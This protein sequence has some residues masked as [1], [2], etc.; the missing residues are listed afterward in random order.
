[1]KTRGFVRAYAPILADAGIDESTW[2]EFLKGFDKSK[3]QHKYFHYVNAAVWVADKVRT[4]VEG[5]SIIARFVTMAI[6]LSVEA[7]RRAYMNKEE[8]KFLDRMNDEF[9]KPRGLFAMVIKFDPKSDEPDGTIDV[10]TGINQKVAKRDDDDRS[11]WKNYFQG[12]S[13]KTHHE[14][15]IPEFAPLVFPELDNLPEEKKEGAVKHFGSFMG[16][17]YDRR[18]QAKFDAENED[19]KLSGVT[20]EHEFASRYSDPNSAA[21]KGGLVSTFSGK[22][23]LVDSVLFCVSSL[24]TPTRRWEDSV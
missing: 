6:H 3:H 11:N 21:S 15:E 22:L 8:N 24:L 19:S 5:V 2:I 18:G 12:S 23:P 7:G 14:D 9:F 16:E 17:Y 4:A 10:T 20:G 1:M 13:G